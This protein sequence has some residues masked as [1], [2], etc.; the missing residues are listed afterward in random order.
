MT[1]QPVDL[2]YE[3]DDRYA[4]EHGRVFVNGD[5][6]LVRLLLMQQ[7]IAFYQDR[8]AEQ[9]FHLLQPFSISAL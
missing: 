2:E 6:A 5:Q 9:I 1:V 8:M 4:R 3:L 7:R